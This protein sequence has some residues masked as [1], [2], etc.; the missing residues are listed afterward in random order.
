MGK[1]HAI[2]LSNDLDDT[3]EIGEKNRDANQNSIS[4]KEIININ[5]NYLDDLDPKFKNSVGDFINELNGHLNGIQL[6]NEQKKI[7]EKQIEGIVGEIT[8]ITSCKKIILDFFTDSTK[9]ASGYNN[10]A[11]ECYD[12]AIEINPQDDDAYNN[13]GLSLYHL[14][15]YNEDY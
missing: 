15:N 8:N 1:G 2:S 9:S 3:D 10:E 14:G 4:M 6:S 11:I 13:K 12:K 5:N 7:L